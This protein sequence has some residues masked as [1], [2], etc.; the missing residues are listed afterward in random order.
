[1]SII[2]LISNR[3]VVIVAIEK[4]NDEMKYKRYHIKIKMKLVRNFPVLGSK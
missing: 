2:N 3:M 1:M 4:F